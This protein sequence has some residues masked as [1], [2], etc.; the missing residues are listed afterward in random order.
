V[1]D[2]EG[3]RELGTGRGGIGENDIE[4]FKEFISDFIFCIYEA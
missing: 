1:R 2:G 4:V 3:R